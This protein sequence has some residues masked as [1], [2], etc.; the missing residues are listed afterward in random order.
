MPLYC[1]LRFTY[2]LHL[3]K[4][5]TIMEHEDFIIDSLYEARNFP[6][7]YQKIA[8]DN[9]LI[10]K[11]LRHDYW[12]DMFSSIDNL[13]E[14]TFWINTPLRQVTIVEL[15]CLSEEL[16]DLFYIGLQ[17]CNLDDIESVLEMYEEND[18]PYIK[19]RIDAILTKVL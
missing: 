19:R 3:L 9:I 17:K 2:C 13:E 6:A 10:I 11:G 12:C 14:I 18:S 4:V 5:Y 1:I 16:D 7:I 15:T 8:E